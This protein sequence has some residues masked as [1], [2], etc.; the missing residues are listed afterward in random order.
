M[1]SATAQGL[2]DIPGILVGH[3]TD[4][5][6]ATGCTVVLCPEGAVASA[7]VAGGAP[8]TRETDLLRP[9][10]LVERLHA[11]LLTGG[12]AFGLDAAGGVMRWLEERG[13]GFPTAAGP[14]PIVVGAV[15]YDLGIGRGDVR[16][17][18]A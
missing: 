6:A 12:S 9:G 3:W 8:G 1:E 14:V 13:V 2:T 17:G 10:F 11:V 15:I 16:P 5:E 18:P 7:E 4:R